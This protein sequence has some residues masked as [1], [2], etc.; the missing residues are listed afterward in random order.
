MEF[1]QRGITDFQIPI[2]TVSIGDWAFSG[3]ELTKVKLSSRIKKIY[4]DILS[5]NRLTHIDI[6]QSVAEIDKMAFYDNEIEN[7]FIPQ[8]VRRIGEKAFFD[9]PLVSFQIGDNVELEESSLGDDGAKDCYYRN[10]R[11][12]GKYVRSVYGEWIYDNN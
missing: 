3:N 9:N 12:Q 5:G 2:D 10:G 1:A 4:P 8:N 7:L 11:V 6:P